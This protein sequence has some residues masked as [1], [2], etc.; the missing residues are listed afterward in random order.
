VNLML[1]RTR[2]NILETDLLVRGCL[3]FV[4]AKI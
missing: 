3:D 1:G 2:P 4:D